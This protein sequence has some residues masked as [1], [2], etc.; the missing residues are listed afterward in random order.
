MNQKEQTKK[1]VHELSRIINGMR[2]NLCK[3]ISEER[4]EEAAVIREKPPL[5]NRN[6]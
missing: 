4:Y 1:K 3:A 5:D 2:G 6:F